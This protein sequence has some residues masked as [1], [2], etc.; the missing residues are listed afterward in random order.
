M[1][2]GKKHHAVVVGEWYFSFVFI[3]HNHCCEQPLKQPSASYRERKEDVC[4]IVIILKEEGLP[5]IT[6]ENIKN[7]IIEV[8]KE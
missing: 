2:V 7:K 8:N 4:A 6:E 5:R 1:D 3:Y